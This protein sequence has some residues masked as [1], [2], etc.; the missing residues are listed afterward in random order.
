MPDLP[1]VGTLTPDALRARR[2]GLLAALL[3]QSTGHE[4][5]PEGLRL[6]F[7]RLPRRWRVSREPSKPSGIA[8]GFS[9]SRS[10][11]SRTIAGCFAFWV[12]VRRGPAP[13]VVVLGIASLVGFALALTRVD[14]AF[15]GSLEILDLAHPAGQWVPSGTSLGPPTSAIAWFTKSSTGVVG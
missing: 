7:A 11:L 3:R 13:W 8:V 14:S 1:I 9:A 2:E 6:R 4:L 5:L 10:R 15:A 12:W